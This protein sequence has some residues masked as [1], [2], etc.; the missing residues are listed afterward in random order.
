MLKGKSRSLRPTLSRISPNPTI[1]SVA[2]TR[3][4][5]RS[6]AHS[7]LFSTLSKR[8]CVF[9]HSSIND[10]NGNGRKFASFPTDAEGLVLLENWGKRANTRRRWSRLAPRKPTRSESARF[11]SK[12][13]QLLHSLERSR[14]G[15]ILISPNLPCPSV[16]R[17]ESESDQSR[18]RA[19]YCHCGWLQAARVRMAFLRTVA[20]NGFRAML[21]VSA[22]ALQILIIAIGDEK[23]E[24]RLSRRS[25]GR[26]RASRE[27]RCFRLHHHTAHPSDGQ[28][29]QR[30][31]RNVSSRHR[32]DAVRLAAE[33][34]PRVGHPG[35]NRPSNPGD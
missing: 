2:S 8:H 33:R 13:F 15:R 23:T 12:L 10:N 25:S 18:C 28:R 1:L 26:P 5:S 21:L 6:P 7:E 11:S 4:L 9:R 19:G 17:T 16:H 22:A 30:F 34:L 14:V 20:E 3:R 27:S 29:A 31:W 24:K 32:A 35:Q